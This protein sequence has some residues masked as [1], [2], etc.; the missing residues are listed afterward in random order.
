MENVNVALEVPL[1][2]HSTFVYAFLPKKKK[3]SNISTGFF[4]IRCKINV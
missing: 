3:E 4:S 2:V 1:S